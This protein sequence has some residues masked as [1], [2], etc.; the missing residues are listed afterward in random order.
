VPIEI[1]SP[2][3]EIIEFP[4]GTQDDEIESVLR[5][6]YGFDPP[7][8]VGPTISNLEPTELLG[9]DARTVPDF[10]ATTRGGPPLS[11]PAGALRSTLAEISGGMGQSLGREE[12]LGSVI[13]AIAP[14]M[15]TFR[16]LTRDPFTSPEEVPTESILAQPPTTPEKLAVGG[17][18]GVDELAHG[19]ADF[20]TSPSGIAQLGL[21]ATPLAPLVAAKWAK[22]MIEGGMIN[23]GDAY[24]AYKRGDMESFAKHVTVGAGL[25]LGGGGIVKHGVT[26]AG[27]FAEEQVPRGTGISPELPSTERELPNALE[28]EAA[29]AVQ[30][31]RNQPIESAGEVPTEVSGRAA[32]VR[33]N[34]PVVPIEET[35]AQ[36]AEV[37]QQ[38]WY[39]D[40]TRATQDVLNSGELRGGSQTQAAQG[41]PFTLP[42]K[43]AGDVDILFSSTERQPL[44]QS[45][46]QQD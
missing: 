20:L 7:R 39:H 30:P 44:G 32:D 8:S 23:A 2:N 40:A 1:E 42:P 25:L 33:G 9:E 5:R 35:P 36:A 26:K 19:I 28:Q 10:Q 14:S 11:L 4:D 27:K 46:K 29:R 21:A 22:D 17:M 31:L 38:L 24:D 3:G 12:G 16:R 6:E 13:P 37:A 18:T 45:T 15:D 41:E 34:Q 43:K